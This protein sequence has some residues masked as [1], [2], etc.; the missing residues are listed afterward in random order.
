MTNQPSNTSQKKSSLY[1]VV[2]HEIMFDTNLKPHHKLFYSFLSG[3]AYGDGSCNPSDSYLAKSFDVSDRC[4]KDWLKLLE[5]HGYISRKTKSCKDN[6]F[7]RTRIITICCSF[8]KQKKSP[9]NTD[10][11]KS[12][13]SAEYCPLDGEADCP[14]EVK[15]IA[16]RVSEY[17]PESKSPPKEESDPIGSSSSST[18]NPPEFLD[19]NVVL[20][21]EEE[22]EIEKRFFERKRQERINPKLSKI[23]NDKAYIQ[24]LRMEKLKDKAAREEK[25]RLETE[26][27]EAMKNLSSIKP[28]DPEQFN[29]VKSFSRFHDLHA[30]SFLLDGNSFDIE[31]RG[32]S[33]FLHSL[34]ETIEVLPFE[35]SG[36]FVSVL[37]DLE[38]RGIQTSQQKPRRLG[39]S[40]FITPPLPITP[41]F[42][43]SGDRA[44]RVD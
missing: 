39:K 40:W 3:L 36:I 7:K 22:E 1:Y 15:Q 34:K 44:I 31:V 27:R 41:K 19:P 24:S 25:R 43:S 10:S 37:E 23:V 2:P 30:K 6:P 20:T 12:Y 17:I 8:K 28:A 13:E 32:N 21:E 18:P 5:N 9:K 16:L 11:K 33:T 29:E 35:T 42:K 4:I 26:A 38:T 14:L